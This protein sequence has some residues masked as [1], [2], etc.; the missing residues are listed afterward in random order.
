MSFSYLKACLIPEF[1]IQILNPRL[2]MSTILIIHFGRKCYAYFVYE[3]NICEKFH[4]RRK[5][6]L[7]LC[8]DTKIK[9]PEF[10]ENMCYVAMA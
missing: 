10:S 1:T 9:W 6:K 3:E 4:Q 8:S 7:Y 2:S 5:I